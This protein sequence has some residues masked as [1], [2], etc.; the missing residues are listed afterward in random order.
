[1]L[2]CFEVKLLLYICHQHLTYKLYRICTWERGESGERGERER[3][4]RERGERERGER[5]KRGKSGESR[6]LR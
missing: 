3:G 2:R 1:M 6:T 4:E 5:G